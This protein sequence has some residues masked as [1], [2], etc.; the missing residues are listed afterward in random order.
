MEDNCISEYMYSVSENLISY[1]DKYSEFLSDLDGKHM[2]ITIDKKPVVFKHKDLHFIVDNFILLH[3]LEFDKCSKGKMKMPIDIMFFK[4]DGQKYIYDTIDTNMCVICIDNNLSVYRGGI[5]NF[6]HV[7]YS[8]NN[9]L[10]AAILHNIDEAMLEII[11]LYEDSNGNIKT[12]KY[13]T[14][15]LFSNN[16]HMYPAI[17][18]SDRYS[19]EYTRSY[20]GFSS[21]LDLMIT[22]MID[23]KNPK[24]T[25]MDYTAAIK[26]D[27]NLGY[28]ATYPIPYIVTFKDLYVSVYEEGG[29]VCMM[30]VLY[31]YDHDTGTIIEADSKTYVIPYEE[32]I[33][34]YPDSRGKET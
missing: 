18:S 5:D 21:N 7:Y 6:W 11:L 1:E 31:V 27:G 24:K 9:T 4:K 12:D 16:Y 26:P 3:S 32:F 20:P 30:D 2:D 17:I 28:M 8:K 13:L 29:S 23:K 34:K 25:V 19:Y 15:P 14:V 33:N 22:D 10:P